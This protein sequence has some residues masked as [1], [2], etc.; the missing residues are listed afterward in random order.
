RFEPDGTIPYRR[1]P[2]HPDYGRTHFAPDANGLTAQVV[3]ALLESA[4][5]SGDTNLMAQALVKLRALDKFRGTVPRGAQ[6]WE[7]PLH[8]P[9]I[10]ASAH[11]VNAYALGYELTGE[12][13]FLDDA[14]YWA[15]T[16]VPFVYLVNPT[17]QKVGSFSTIAVLGATG[18][19]AP[20]WFGRPVQW[21]GLVYA[22]ALHRLAKHDAAFPWA[23]IANGITAA[24]LQ[25]TWRADDRERVGLLP[26]YYELLIQ[27]SAGPAINPATIGVSAARLFGRGPVFDRQVF[28]QAGL[29]VQAPSA[30]QPRADDAERISFATDGWPGGVCSVLVSGFSKA[31]TVRV[32]GELCRWDDSHA[33]NAAAGWLVLKL[34]GRSEVEIQR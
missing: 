12:R 21:C 18:W 31:P 8:T 34:D 27:Q 30:I 33:F 25:H 22:D 15:W 23:K 28:R 24:G 16:G 10:L 20:V 4:V 17:G 19:K 6:T 14:I 1:S 13:Q 29:V 2:D 3:A 9:D 26:D 32:N 7:I 5:F 11:L